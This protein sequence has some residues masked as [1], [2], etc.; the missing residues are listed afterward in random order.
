MILEF[1]EKIQEQFDTQNPLEKDQFSIKEKIEFIL[2]WDKER[3]SENTLLSNISQ[4]WNTS[5]I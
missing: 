4:I 5:K 1:Y 3:A 2:S